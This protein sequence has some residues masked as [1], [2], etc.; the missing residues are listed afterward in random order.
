MNEPLPTAQELRVGLA[1]VYLGALA[2][3][4]DRVL[5]ACSGDDAAACRILMEVLRAEGWR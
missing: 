2:R 3:R 5:K 1:L 4:Y